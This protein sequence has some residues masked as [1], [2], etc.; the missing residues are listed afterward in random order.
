[1]TATYCTVHDT[2]FYDAGAAGSVNP[3]TSRNGS[4]KT[5]T[6][7][8]DLGEISREFISMQ[9]EFYLLGMGN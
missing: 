5:H 2:T 1:M 6:L 9:E 4:Q 8:G 7:D 3:A